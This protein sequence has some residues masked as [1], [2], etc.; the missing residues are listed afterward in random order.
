M[1][2]P[3]VPAAITELSIFGKSQAVSAGHLPTFQRH[4]GMLNPLAKSP[5]TCGWKAPNKVRVFINGTEKEPPGIF[6]ISG[7]VCPL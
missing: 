1:K 6:H 2:H 3:L 7:A 5:Q 4:R